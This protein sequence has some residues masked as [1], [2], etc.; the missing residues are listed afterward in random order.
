MAPRRIE[1]GTSLITSQAGQQPADFTDVR[2]TNLAVVLRFVRAEAPCSRADIAASTGL[3]KA[4][5]SSLVAELI[6]RRLVREIGLTEHRI[7]RPAT[8]IVLDGAAYAAVG[9]E[10]NT[11]HLTAVAIDLAG[12]RLLSW[13]R[14]FAGRRTPPAKAVATVAALA[15]KAVA[16]VA[17]EDREVLG[18]TV[19]VAGLV[20]DSGVVRL[21][22]N[23]G[24]R[25]LPLRESLVQAMDTPTIPVAVEND[26]NLAVRAEYRYG[27]HAGVQNLVYVNGHAGVG[28]GIIADGR[29]LRGGL[30]YSG[31]LGHV[32]V[33]PDGPRCGCGRRGCLETV[34]SV[35]ALISRVGGDGDPVDLDPEVDDLVR[36]AK[37][38]EPLVLDALRD[39][40]RHLGYGVSIL[41]NVVNPEVVILGGYFVPLAPW[42]MP[43][44]EAEM[45]DKTAAP[46]AGGCRL[47]PSTLGQGAAATGGAA[48]ILD[49]VDSGR[50]PAPRARTGVGV[51]A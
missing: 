18:L 42:I 47:M 41:S 6:E 20:D 14:A 37:A 15:R 17:A 8:M 31:E 21:G 1:S 44:A 11:D 40:G 26:A 4:T 7:G 35:N 27:P 34:A 22:P 13:R 29:L 36:R 19:G 45:W 32:Q 25:D 3:N 30:G 39:L 51:S 28:A 43:A 9:I 23:L 33:D 38:Q 24:W 50:L 48:S 46:N 12:V 5:V 2:A 16:K 10:V 49:T